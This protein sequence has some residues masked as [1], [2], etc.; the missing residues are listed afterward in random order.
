MATITCDTSRHLVYVD[1]NVTERS[2]SGSSAT[3][4]STIDY[5][6]VI[7]KGSSGRNSS[8]TGW[9]Q[10]IYATYYI[11]GLGTK[12][13]YIPTYNYNGNVPP[14]STIA[15]GSFEIEH[16]NDGSKTVAFNISFTDN[17]NG[18]NDGSYY[19]P[20]NGA[21]VSGSLTC[22]V[23]PRYT[24]VSTWSVASKTETSITLN[25]KTSETVKSIRYGTSTSSYSTAT[26]DSTSGQVTITGLSA[27]TA[28]TLYFMPCRKDS[29]LW[30]D[31]SNGTWKS[32]GGQS[33]YDWPK[34]T[35][36]PDFTIGTNFTVSLYNP[37]G[38]SC[39]IYLKGD[40]NS[41]GSVKTT[42]GTSVTDFNNSTWNTF[43]YNSIP[44]KTGL[45]SNNK[46]QY[47]VRLVCSAVSRDTTV[48]GGY[49]R[50]KNDGTE[51]PNFSDS[52]WSYS[53]DRTNL[54]G[55]NQTIIKQYST[56]TFTVG[57]AAT[58]SYGASIVKYIYKWGTQSKDSTSGNTLSG[59]LT[60]VLGVDAVDSRGLIKATTKTL[61]SGTNFVPYN[62]PTLDYSNCYTHR[63]DGILAET[64][65]TLM[66]N[67]S[68]MKFGSSGIANSLNSVKYRVYDYSMS[69]WSS[70][71]TIPVNSFTLQSSGYFSLNNYTI[72][73][74]GS[75]G[76][77]A[78]GKRYAVQIML[79]DA[80]GTLA[81]L[82]SN[83]ILV[84]DGK[85][86]RD[87]YQDSN[88]DYHQ[89]INGMADSNYIE[90]IY[91]DI[92]VDGTINGYTLDNV[93]E[94]G[95]NVVDSW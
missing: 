62:T 55:T 59:G 40:N 37:L 21:Q 60:N 34:I 17:A 3:N 14:G 88:G 87:V 44:N 42:T 41:Q 81:T 93:C 63:T 15:S 74:N 8:W 75:S 57:T 24:T 31:G 38:R 80:D 68:V 29:S 45:D 30:G 95:Y 18:N 10:R 33:T 65:L 35:T 12:K 91:G 26:V 39:S 71:F 86:A 4:K 50:I 11:E 83:N 90:K 28:Y 66:G 1:L 52:N 47:K 48:N 32:L 72:H 51:I 54:T 43:W 53:G 56:I 94:L 9:G 58:S 92:Y 78:T 82:T 85:I 22:A 73:A 69:S 67:L 49:Y 46:A 13:V 25:W 76:G 70:L 7:R 19:T 6:V 84:T 61:V 89:G 77:F 5:S 16:A 27:N 79:T 64:K 20:G 2:G 36:T 23:I